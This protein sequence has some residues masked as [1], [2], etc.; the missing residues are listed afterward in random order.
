MGFDI[1][2]ADEIV[3]EMAPNFSYDCSNNWCQ[4][5]EGGLSVVEEVRWW[6][7][8]LRYGCDDTN[9]PGEEN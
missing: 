3:E 1:L 9:S 8:E 4:I 5:E 2:V 6:T 7:N